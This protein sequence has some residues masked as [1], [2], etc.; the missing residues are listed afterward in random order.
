MNVTERFLKYVS[1]PT[2][3]AEGMGRTPSTPGQMALAEELARELCDIGLRDARVDGFGYVYASLPANT[4]KK[5][6]TVGF[7]A[8]M[9]TAKD[10]PG[11]V[12]KPRLVEYT[13]EDIELSAGIFLRRA[14]YPCLD[15]YMG[16]TLVVTDGKTLLGADDKAGIAE[17]MTALREIT[18]SGMPHGEIRVAFTPD[19]EI[20]EG[21]D[22]FDVAGFSADYAYTVDGGALGEVEY[23]NFNAASARIRINGVSIHPGSAKDRMK[24]AARIAAEFD[25]LLP[26]DEI[27]ERTEGYE[28]F[29]HLISIS[30]ACEE[31]ELVYIIRDHDMGA[32]ESKKADFIRAGGLIN[33]KYGEGTLDISIKDSYFNMSAVIEKNMFVVE[34]AKEA[35]TRVG[36][37]PITVPI[38]GGTDGARLSFMG[39]P[40]PNLSTGGENF[41]SRFEFVSVSSM[42]KMVEVLVSIARGAYED[43]YHAVAD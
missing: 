42:E 12:I 8:H 32:F 36:V 15:G 5:T 35:M 11:A 13:G 2:A 41:H 9:D 23:E 3:S 24:N 28:G 39:L 1:Y 4:D 16:Q 37:D 27:P 34:R 40:C 6:N 21:A 14:D 25:S 17:I 43:G 33:E 31:A 26:R 18:D 22:H 38:R 10:A 20:G 29:H 7:F 30:G 19:E